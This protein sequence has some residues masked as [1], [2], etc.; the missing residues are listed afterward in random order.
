MLV[1]IDQPQMGKIKIA[2]SPLRLSATPGEVYAPAP[3]L[4]EHTEEILRDLLNY[5]AEEITKLKEAGVI[6]S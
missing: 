6:N 4:G 5:S 3:L 1:G 2:G